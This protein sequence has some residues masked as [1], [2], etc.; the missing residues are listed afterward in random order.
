[1]SVRIRHTVSA[2]AV[3]V[4]LRRLTTGADTSMPASP[5]SVTFSIV[6]PSPFR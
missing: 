1:M 4:T 2:G 5:V 3:T 6:M